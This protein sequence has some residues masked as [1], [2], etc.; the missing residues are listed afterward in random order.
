MQQEV[1]WCWV[2][3]Q[4][5]TEHHWKIYIL[6]RKSVLKCNPEC[7]NYV[8][9][10]MKA[11]SLCGEPQIAV[12]DGNIHCVKVCITAYVNNYESY[13]SEWHTKL[14]NGNNPSWAPW[15][16]MWLLKYYRKKRSNSLTRQ[17]PA[18]NMEWEVLTTNH[19]WV[20][21]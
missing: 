18:I 16:K 2:N 15:D 10:S 9:I 13:Q 11:E 3:F 5:W 6:H 8:W 14:I 7:Q 12:S 1:P 17:F 19:W 4:Y 21:M 20:I